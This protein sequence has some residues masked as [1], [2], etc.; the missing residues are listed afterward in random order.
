MPPAEYDLFIIGAGSGG[1]RAARLAAQ[2]G[3]RV[4]VAESGELG[5]TCVNVGCVPKK[6]YSFAAH[7]AETFEEAHG[8][9]WPVHDPALDWPTLKRNRGIEIARLN[10]VY[11]M[12]L[13]NAGV[14]LINGRARLAG[15]DAV[16][17]GGVVYRAKHIIV[18]T[19]SWPAAP[20]VPG[21]ELAISSNEIFDLAEFPRRLVVVGGG[22]IAC[23]FASIFNGLGA[24]VAQFYRAHQVLRGFDD[25]VRAFVADEMRKKGVDLRTHTNVER[26]DRVDDGAPDAAALRVTL[27]DGA[28]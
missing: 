16:E 5:G 11:D 15:A 10:D 24:Q 7:Y 18:A 3:V 19:G 23:E 2:L 12:L 22:Y 6:L 9:G 4:A 20:E 13:G 8:F 28:T 1:V 21:G 27:R 26:I 25:D 14:T 17:V